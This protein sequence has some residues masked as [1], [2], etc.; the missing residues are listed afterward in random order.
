MLLE[1]GIGCNLVVG[2]REVQVLVVPALS[3]SG[4]AYYVPFSGAFLVSVEGVP[5]LALV[6]QCFCR[7]APADEVEIPLLLGEQ[8]RAAFILYDLIGQCAFFGNLCASADL[9]ERRES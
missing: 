3:V 6:C 1:V 9:V 7:L 5:G 8:F 2:E 4:R